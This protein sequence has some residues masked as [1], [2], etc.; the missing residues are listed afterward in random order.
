MISPVPNNELK[1]TEYLLR[2]AVNTADFA[3]GVLK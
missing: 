1:S 2:E 3:C